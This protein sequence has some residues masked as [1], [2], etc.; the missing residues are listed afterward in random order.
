MKK[1]TE[2]PVVIAAPVDP[3]RQLAVLAGQAMQ[4]RLNVD[5]KPLKKAA[6]YL[7]PGKMKLLLLA[8]AGGAALLSLAKSIGRDSVYRSVVSKELK[9][10]LEP[11]NESLEE[12]KRQNEELKRQNE[13]LSAE[14]SGL[15]ANG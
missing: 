7:E 4:E 9:K 10:Q 12:L 14:L 1:K 15:R 11:V 13:A 3:K 8:V 2:L 5:L 6:R